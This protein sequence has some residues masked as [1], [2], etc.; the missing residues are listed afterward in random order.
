MND[1]IYVRKNESSK[2]YGEAT[3]VQISDDNLKAYVQFNTDEQVIRQAVPLS[4]I[5]ELKDENV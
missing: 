2:Y 1:K 5:E 4:S 3:L